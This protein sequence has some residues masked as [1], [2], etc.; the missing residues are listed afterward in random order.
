[1]TAQTTRSSGDNTDTGT[2]V[3]T[4]AAA[5]GSSTYG[6]AFRLRDQAGGRRFVQIDRDA[7]AVDIGPGTAAAAVLAHDLDVLDDGAVTP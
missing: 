2:G 6:H 1:V 7:L 3:G 5:S 4:C